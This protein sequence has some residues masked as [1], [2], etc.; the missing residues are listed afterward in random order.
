MPDKQVR[1]DCG[2][3][4]RESNDDSL[5]Q[6]VQQH[7]RDVHHKDISRDQVMQMAEPSSRSGSARE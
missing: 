7:S 6:A 5:V 1:C 2:T 4:I 3:V